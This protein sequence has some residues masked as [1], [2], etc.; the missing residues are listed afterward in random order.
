VAAA[1]KVARILVGLFFVFV[2]ALELVHHHQFASSFAHWGVPAAAAS[3]IGVGALEVVCGVLLT[4]AVLTRPVALLL[5]TVMVG[6]V[7]TA[8]R[9]DGGMH[10]VV[11]P[12]LFLVCVVLAWRTGR[13]PAAAPARPPGVQ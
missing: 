4:F 5:A 7:M 6:A 1:L 13:F 11:P 3:V 8:G 12:L 9:A 2:G 10:L